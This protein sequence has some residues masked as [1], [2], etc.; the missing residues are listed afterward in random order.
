MKVL[1]I[2]CSVGTISLYVAN[3]GNEILG[4]DISE[5]AINI[6]QNSAELLGI[7]NA[8]FKAINFLDTDLQEKFDFI[9]CSEIL[10]HLPE[11]KLALNKIHK[12]LTRGGILCIDVPTESAPL[13]RLR[14]YLF[15]KDAFD[16]SLEHLRRYS[17]NEIASI[18]K[19]LG[20]KIIENQE[21]EG[22]LRN[23]LFTNKVGNHLLFFIRLPIFKTFFTFFDNT[24]KR[25]FGGSGV[26]LIAKKGR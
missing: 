14:M 24:L 5:N 11:D 25:L 9:I 17:S 21:I 18:L 1:D 26:I 2:G 10:E 16:V 13:H 22:I 12:L 23:F 4:I 8:S 15:K 6:A 19:N 7:K 20:F 3:K